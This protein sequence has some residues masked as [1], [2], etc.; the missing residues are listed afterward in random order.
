[1]FA[2]CQ[3]MLVLD[4]EWRK[5]CPFFP[6]YIEKKEIYKKS[7]L[8]VLNEMRRKMIRIKESKQKENSRR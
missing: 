1:M 7:D 6:A 5:K 2:L 3:R 8:Y 4:N